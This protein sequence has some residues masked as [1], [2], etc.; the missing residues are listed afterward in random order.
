MEV[1]VELKRA[2]SSGTGLFRLPNNIEPP[3]SLVSVEILDTNIEFKARIRLYDGKPVVYVPKEIAKGLDGGLVIRVTRI[4]GNY[5]KV[6]SD[7]RIYLKKD[8]VEQYGIKPRSIIKIITKDF[9]RF[10]TVNYRKRNHKEEYMCMVGPTLAK[11]TIK[12]E[13]ENN[14]EK[15]AGNVGLFLPKARIKYLRGEA[16]VSINNARNISLASNIPLDKYAYYLGAYFADGTK[17]G[18]SWALCASSTTQANYYINRHSSI[19]LKP[20]FNFAITYTNF[21]ESDP[22]IEK[23]VRGYWKEVP[24]A[25]LRIIRSKG[26]IRSK[27]TNEFGTLVIKEN[28]RTI[29]KVYNALLSGFFKLIKKSR[30]KKL[31]RIFIMGILEGDGN[32]SSL[33]HGHLIITTNSAEAALL[34]PL[35]DISGLDYR[36]N[37]KNNVA[38][39]RINALSILE[40]LPE[41]GPHIFRY[42]PNRRELFCQR[43]CNNIGICRFLLGKQDYASGWV[44]SELSKR[45]ILTGSLYRP[46]A[47]GKR[48]VDSL[49]KLDCEASNQDH[50]DP[51]SASVTVE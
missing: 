11:K 25:K 50:D 22:E 15:P 13:I 48:I 33:G 43:F 28:S 29:V 23:K 49:R 30:N 4:D 21:G 10:V 46:T 41:L 17:K 35:L 39:I 47:L 31:A 1:K 36:M 16:I 7:G 42:Y 24:R 51:G 2:N 37:V 45:N 32:V 38:S 40:N 19:V 12:F 44:K 34:R 6:G 5:A 27:K 26:K 14:Y 8:L 18:N 3:N 20:K 9:S